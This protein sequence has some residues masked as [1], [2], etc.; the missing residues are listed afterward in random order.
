MSYV[1]RNH[2]LFLSKFFSLL[3]EIDIIKSFKWVMIMENDY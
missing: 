3:E 2:K 1:F